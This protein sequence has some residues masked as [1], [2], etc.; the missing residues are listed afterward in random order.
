MKNFM[1]A[2]A[3]CLLLILGA[4]YFALALVALGGMVADGWLGWVDER[5][6]SISKWGIRGHG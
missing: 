2:P 5:I 1:R 6:D 3:L 4:L